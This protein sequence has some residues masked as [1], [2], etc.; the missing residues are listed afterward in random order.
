MILYMIE[1]DNAHVITWASSREDAKRKA[2]LW[3]GGVSD[4]YICTPLTE[5]GD[6]VHLDIT[7][8]I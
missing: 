6:R 4:N 8:A 5:K 1:T 2:Q 3:L 7:L